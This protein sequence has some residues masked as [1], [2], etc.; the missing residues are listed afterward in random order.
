MSLSA[1]FI[2]IS[3]ANPVFETIAKALQKNGIQGFL[4]GGFVRDMLLNRPCKDI[5]IS[6]LGDGIA[7]AQ[8]TAD[9]L[10]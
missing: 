1:P 10:H 8:I 3:K 7:A 6:V 5:D 2:A 9:Q 4:I